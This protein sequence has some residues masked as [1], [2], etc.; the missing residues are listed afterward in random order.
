MCFGLLIDAAGPVGRRP[1][2]G[3][4]GS[5]RDYA[6][7]LYLLGMP[8]FWCALTMRR[9]PTSELDKFLYLLLNL[10]CWRFSAVLGAVCS[11]SA[12]AWG[13]PSTSGT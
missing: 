2:P 11:R 4:G 5:G 12:A 1:Q 6:F 10:G 9:T 8:T 13:W 7:W 3:S